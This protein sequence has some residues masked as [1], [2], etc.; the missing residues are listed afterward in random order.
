M[1]TS[2]QPRHS[3]V[4]YRCDKGSKPLSSKGKVYFPVIRFLSF[5]VFLFC[6]SSLLVE[7]FKPVFKLVKER[8]SCPAIG[9]AAYK[10]SPM[11]A[12]VLFQYAYKPLA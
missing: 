12:S 7:S 5:L 10:E 3:G 9:L 2:S 11:V 6:S 1:S 4:N 8:V